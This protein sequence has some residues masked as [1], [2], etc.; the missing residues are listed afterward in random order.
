MITLFIGKVMT[1]LN[2]RIDVQYILKK[3][4][5]LRSGWPLYVFYNPLTNRFLSNT[6]GT[7]V[8]REI[9]E[10]IG[11]NLVIGTYNNQSPPENVLEDIQYFLD[12]G[13]F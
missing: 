7:R 5:E 4:R 13:G 3:V 10:G 1:A 2:Q 11:L 12:H 9:N 8:E 6:A